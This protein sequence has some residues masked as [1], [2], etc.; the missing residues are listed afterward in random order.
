MKLRLPTWLC[1]IG[2][3]K[4]NIRYCSKGWASRLAGSTSELSCLI[5]WFC[6]HEKSDYGL[7]S[8]IPNPNSSSNHTTYPSSWSQDK[9]MFYPKTFS[10]YSS[11][12]ITYCFVSKFVDSEVNNNMWYK[13]FNLDFSI[14]WSLYQVC[15]HGY[16]KWMIAEWLMNTDNHVRVF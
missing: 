7:V 5:P 4:C 14:T 2:C 1:G 16:I 15:A 10:F 12:V 8:L 13:L 3:C 11:R 9:W 6:F